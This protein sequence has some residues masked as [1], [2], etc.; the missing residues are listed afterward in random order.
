MRS[1][2]LALASLALLVAAREA[3]GE[4]NTVKLCGRDFVRAIV[5]TCGGSRWKRHLTDYRYLFEGENPLP[6]SP[7]NNI[8]A[9]SWRYTDQRLETIDEEI[10][11]DKPETERDLQRT[12]KKSM[13]KKREV[14]KLLTTSCCSIGCS[15][16]EISSLC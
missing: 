11:N 15:K 8:Y 14:A 5:F 13:L 6:F 10:H 16:R 12:R 7:E 9:D 1:T 3:K 2:V 4:G